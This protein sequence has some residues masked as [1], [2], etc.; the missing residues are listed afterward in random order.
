MQ[1]LQWDI[2]NDQQQS[3]WNKA[4]KHEA[5]EI[6]RVLNWIAAEKYTSDYKWIKNKAERLFACNSQNRAIILKVT[7]WFGRNDWSLQWQWWLN[8]STALHDGEKAGI[9]FESCSGQCKLLKLDIFDK[10]ISLYG[11][12]YGGS[13]LMKN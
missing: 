12:G 5:I 11:Y 6:R 3:N 9:G 8:F 2:S 7:V 1:V 4:Q 10:Y 13:N